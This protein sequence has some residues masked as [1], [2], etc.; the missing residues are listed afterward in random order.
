MTYLPATTSIDSSRAR[1]H[2]VELRVRRPG[3]RHVEVAGE[4][5]DWLTPRA[6][7]EEEPGVFAR[8]FALPGGAYLYKLRVDDAW[9]LDE[10]NARTRT[11]GP[12]R[13]N[14]LSVGAAEE[15]LLFAPAPPFVFEEDG[16]GVVVTA[17]LRRGSGSSLDVLWREGPRAPVRRTP[18]PR[19]L[20]E[21]EHALH[22]VRLPASSRRLELAFAIDGTRRGGR[23]GNGEAFV[24]DS[25]VEHLPPA[26][27]RDAVV[28]AI[29]VDRFRPKVDA[30]GWERDP[31]ADVA[32]GGHLDGIARS[33]DDLAELGVTALYLTPCHVASS[34]HRYD[35]A[36]PLRVDPALGG[37]AA[38]ARLVA[39]AHA[40]GLRVLIDFALGHAGRGFAPY[41]TVLEDGPESPA[42]AYF[43][44]TERGELCHYGAR[45]DAPLLDLDAPE[46]RALAMKALEA[47]AARGIDG[48]RLDAAAEVPIDL[49]RALRSRLRELRPEAVVLGEVV[50]EHAWRWRAE[51][52][53]DAATDF[54]FPR[55]SGELFARG[56]IDAGVATDAL[57]R[58]ELARGGPTSTALRFVST[59]DH[60]RFA[61][62]ARVE[63]RGRNA[64]L[65]LVHLLT[66][67]GVPMLLYGEELGLSAPV[68]ELAP[69]AAWADRMPMP[70]RP[71]RRDERF[72]AVVR[73]LLAARA[74]SVA[75][76]R[77]D[78]TVLHASGG[79]LVL[80]RSAEGE[81]VDVAMNGGEE[82]IEVEI[83]DPDRSAI[84]LLATV[85]E[86]GIHGSLLALGPGAAVVAR[87]TPAPRRHA[88]PPLLAANRRRAAAFTSR[89]VGRVPLPARLDFALTESCNLRCAH[90]ITSAPERTKSGRARAMTPWVLDRLRDALPFVEYAGFVHGGEPLTSPLLYDV[91]G[92]L[93]SARKG[94]PTMVHLLTNGVLLDERTTARLAEA[95]VGSISVSLDGATAEVNDRIRVGGDF[96]A[97]CEN[98][99][100]AVRVRR[101][102]GADLRLGISSVVWRESAEQVEALVEL[103]SRLGVDWLKLEEVAPVNPFAAR[104]VVP[105]DDAGLRARVERAVARGRELGVVVVDHTA[106]PAV[107]RC[108]LG[109]D[110]AMRAFLAADEYA[111]RSVIHP[112]RAAW[113]R[114]CVQPD[115]DVHLGDFFGPRLG[116]VVEEPL[117]AIWNGELAR[118]ERSAGE[119]TRLCGARPPSCEPEPG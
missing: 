79:V 11:S 81:V 34:S 111:N 10:A 3:A 58:A 53:V 52:A 59:H 21:G 98:V 112:C 46:V 28:Y 22:R 13:N 45:T 54:A 39:G 90:C 17:G 61:T 105:P 56:T 86:V 55:V 74:A 114:A 106:P 82:P 87:R 69:E 68:A 41:E 103:A 36:D 51:G 18:M 31:G 88:P 101:A 85:G 99:R 24:I 62:L 78:S 107:W 43:Q 12:F 116:N 20:D 4:L 38:F 32:A 89:A 33:L 26:W 47:W 50:P 76:R 60:A 102:L 19:I 7:E 91:L 71:H 27:W 72:R 15:P 29:F 16:G 66:S 2:S 80:R 6:L 73:R 35:F 119:Q 49:A 30:P 118:I 84:E 96:H 5:F 115:G 94:A 25:R 65:G 83:S 109:E 110:A 108:R 97:V 77:G 40:R 57:L 95:G 23:S 44:W 37:E 75:L 63:R 113:E 1:L 92:A 67:T 9:E 64:A 70:W 42:A 117:G 14:V 8:R 104:A 100:G 48:I 93:R